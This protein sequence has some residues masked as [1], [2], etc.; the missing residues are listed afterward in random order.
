MLNILKKDSFNVMGE[1]IGVYYCTYGLHEQLEKLGF[2]VKSHTREPYD[3]DEPAYEI[4]GQYAN[5]II[6]QG[7]D[8]LGLS[9]RLT[10]SIKTAF[11]LY[12]AIERP[13]FYF[14]DLSIAD[15]EILE[16]INLLH[17]KTNDDS[18]FCWIGETLEES[19]FFPKNGKKYYPFT[20]TD[21][22]IAPLLDDDL[23]FEIEDEDCLSDYEEL[24][25]RVVIF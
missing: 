21:F 25:H 17:A 1:K 14:N 9:I 22:H 3:G 11:R 24:T 16:K 19:K 6:E 2:E 10:D 12:K 13:L 20:R 23:S 7:K 18:H 15:D 5:V 4:V 8:D